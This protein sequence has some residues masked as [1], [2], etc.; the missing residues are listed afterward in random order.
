MGDFVCALIQLTIA[1]ALVPA[2]N[3]RGVG[4]TLDALLEQIVHAQSGGE[5]RLVGIE[6]D[7]QFALFGLPKQ[8]RT[9]NWPIR[10]G[11]D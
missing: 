5:S 10:I 1:G 3:G 11:G 7:Q 2:A 8:S 9:G 6:L 4:R